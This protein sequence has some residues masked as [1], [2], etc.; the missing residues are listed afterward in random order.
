MSKKFYAIAKGKQPG[1]YDDWAKAEMQIK[2]FSGAVFKS[3][4]TFD[5]SVVWYESVANAAPQLFLNAPPPVVSAQEAAHN[6]APKTPLHAEALAA[7]KVVIYTD[8][9]CDPN[10]GPGGYGVV[11]L[12]GALPKTARK[13]LS[14]GFA[15]TTN[16]RMEIM[17]CIVALQSL[18][19]KSEVALFGDSQYVLNGLKQGW[20]VRWRQNNW[21]RTPKEKAV[22]ADLWA[23]LLD[24]YE[25]HT[26]EL[27][28]T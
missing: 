9:G 15:H 28:W 23:K 12:F 7:G 19:R 20:A 11:L 8:G 13:E 17:A 4:T 14:G 22:N 16:N 3:F 25:Q 5:A 26:V 18:N 6:R 24:V 1:I 27:V 2:G 10:P 21:M